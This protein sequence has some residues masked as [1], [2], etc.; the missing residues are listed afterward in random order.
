MN[1]G[2]SF[3]VHLIWRETSIQNLNNNFRIITT[4]KDQEKRKLVEWS[5]VTKSN[6]SSDP[7]QTH[8][9]QLSI[10]NKIP[11]S[12]LYE[13]YMIWRNQQGWNMKVFGTIRIDKVEKMRNQNSI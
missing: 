4:H 2:D 13:W 5:F 6:F 3:T 1:S 7:F 9:T 8:S 10:K 11:G 12:N